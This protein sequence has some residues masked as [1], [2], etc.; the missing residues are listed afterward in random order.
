MHVRLAVAL[1][2]CLLLPGAAARAAEEPKAFACTFTNGVSF[3]YEKGQF[4]TEKASALSFGVAAI[5]FQAQTAE[6]KTSRG[7]GHLRVAQ[8]VNATHFLE[9]VT[10]GYLHV[11]TIYE[12]DEANGTYPAVH[13]RH[14]S[15]LG[16]PLVAQY[17]GFCEAK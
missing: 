9:V 10:E 2:L 15:V 6:L 3:S 17:Q 7:T 12:K 14:F 8:A 16:Q 5:D 13:S 4:A 11:T 1:F